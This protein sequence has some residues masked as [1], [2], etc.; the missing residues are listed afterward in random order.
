M[1]ADVSNYDDEHEKQVWEIAEKLAKI[2]A[3]KNEGSGLC[4]CMG[5]GCGQLE[6]TIFWRFLLLDKEQFKKDILAV[7]EERYAR[8]RP[9]RRFDTK[10]ETKE[11]P[12]GGE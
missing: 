7:L 5:A 12:E 1:G 10:I 9:N 6:C 11:E 4:A 2:Y 8:E 3:I